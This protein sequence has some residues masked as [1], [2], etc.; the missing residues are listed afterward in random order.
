[1]AGHPVN[2]RFYEDKGI[3]RVTI[4]RAIIEASKL[5]WKDTDELKI[6]VETINGNK[7]LFIYKPAK[8]IEKKE[9]IKKLKNS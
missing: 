8:E 9:G 4:P 1:M 2:Y 7:G 5:D 6:V 3:S